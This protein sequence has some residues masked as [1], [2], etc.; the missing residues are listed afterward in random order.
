MTCDEKGV[1]SSTYSSIASMCILIHHLRRGLIA[2]QREGVPRD[3]L[4]SFAR[5]RSARLPLSAKPLCV[6]VTRPHGE[7]R[8]VSIGT[9]RDDSAHPWLMKECQA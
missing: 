7:A 2:G 3:K 1:S 6:L 5:G 9:L 4:M 8:Q